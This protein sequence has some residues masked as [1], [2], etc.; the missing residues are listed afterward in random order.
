MTEGLVGCLGPND[1]AWQLGNM[2][3]GSSQPIALNIDIER[4]IKFEE[5]A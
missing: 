5:L 3:D 2:G 1:A 4:F